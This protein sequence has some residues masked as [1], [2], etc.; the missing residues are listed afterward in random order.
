[1]DSEEKELEKHLKAL[2]TAIQQTYGTT[3]ALVWRSFLS[4]LMSGLGAT[5]GVSVIVI[6]I[7]Y[8]IRHFGGL[9]VIGNWLSDLEKVL[10]T[11]R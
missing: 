8:L 2:T 1:M 7:G 4:G 6:L 5:I 3:R 11:K 10:P 9:P